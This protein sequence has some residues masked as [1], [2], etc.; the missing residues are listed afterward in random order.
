MKTPFTS[1]LHFVRCACD[2]LCCGFA[3]DSV[4][5]GGVEPSFLSP[6]GSLDTDGTDRPLKLQYLPLQ[7]VLIRKFCFIGGRKCAVP[8]PSAAACEL[9]TGRKTRPSALL[10]GRA[11][12]G[13]NGIRE[14]VAE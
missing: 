5:D 10:K 12:F 14:R 3:L 8:I 9:L 1:R 7:S 11:P 4:R 6:F 13:W 2:G